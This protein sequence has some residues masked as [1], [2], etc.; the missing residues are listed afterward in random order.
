MARKTFRTRAKWPYP[1]SVS[2]AAIMRAA[3]RIADAHA[4]DGIEESDRDELVQHIWSFIQAL[5]SEERL[6]IVLHNVTGLSFCEIAKR[7]HLK[8]KNVKRGFDEACEK[9]K[10]MF[11]RFGTQSL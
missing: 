5:T 2:D 6:L 4:S 8:R 1:D 9:L 10:R 3:R 11:E 7:E